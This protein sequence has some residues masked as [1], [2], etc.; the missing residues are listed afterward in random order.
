MENIA[1]YVVTEQVIIPSLILLTNYINS[2]IEFL[3][4]QVYT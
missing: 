3:E 1:T 2:L 4:T